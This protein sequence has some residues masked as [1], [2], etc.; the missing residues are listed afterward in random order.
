MAV[1]VARRQ[2]EKWEG[3]GEITIELSVRDHFKV[4]KA[5]AGL[6]M[7]IFLFS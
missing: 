3:D 4:R 5:D 7:A 2:V 6:E 1:K